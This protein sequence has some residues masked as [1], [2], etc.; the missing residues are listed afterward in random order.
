MISKKWMLMASACLLARCLV[1]ATG[2]IAF[3]TDVV[4]GTVY[5]FNVDDT[6][7]P[8]TQILSGIS[9]PVGITVSPDG[10][11]VY[12]TSNVP[13]V[14]GGDVYSFPSNGPYVA[15][16]LNTGMDNPL[17]IA[18]S[19]DGTTGFVTDGTNIWS[20]PIGG[21]SHTASMLTSV[22]A[23]VSGPAFIAISGNT[24]YLGGFGNFA[25]DSVYTFPISNPASGQT[26][27]NAAL[28]VTSGTYEVN[29][30]TVSSDNN[31]YYSSNINSIL[32]AS[33]FQV[34]LSLIPDPS[35]NYIIQQIFNGWYGLAVSTDGTTLY[36]ASVGNGIY[37][38]PT[39]SGVVLSPTLLTSLNLANP[40]QIAIAAHTFSP[41]PTPDS[42]S[43][44]PPTNVVQVVRE[45]RFLSQSLFWTQ[46]YWDSTPTATAEGYYVYQNGRLIGTLPITANSFTI[47]NSN[48]SNY[49]VSAYDSAGNE[50]ARVTATTR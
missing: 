28:A 8:A 13:A 6:S 29:G 43:I 2:S 10:S 1:H 33:I 16:R 20:F 18:I 41:A 15:T 19:S 31:L 48:F 25:I 7:T 37:S 34:P 30:L 22:G 27:Y 45:N 49:Q 39:N 5:F 3:V 24:G 38:M 44:N 42:A 35:P 23:T 47:T 50:S 40:F 12:Y 32:N 26:T 36:A 14:S 17:G 21:S 4:D 46:L 9:S 11:T